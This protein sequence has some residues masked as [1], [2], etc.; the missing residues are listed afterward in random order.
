MR[1]QLELQ[2]LVEQQVS[3]LELHLVL[4]AVE[5][6][7]QSRSIRNPRSIRRCCNPTMQELT[8]RKLRCHRNHM[9][10]LESSIHTMVLEPSNRTMVLLGP[11]IH[12]MELLERSIHTMVLE[13]SI[14]M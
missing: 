3:L 9:M 2:V 6:P 1:E 8:S 12:R 5:L 13:R 7:S 11:S 14:R 10:E 4:V